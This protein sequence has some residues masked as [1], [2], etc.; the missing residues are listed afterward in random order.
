M[1]PGPTSEFMTEISAIVINNPQQICAS[2][3]QS[4]M[5]EYIHP[6]NIQGLGNGELFS[7]VPSTY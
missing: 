2:D 1:H 7:K 3:S 4:I 5:P 6:R